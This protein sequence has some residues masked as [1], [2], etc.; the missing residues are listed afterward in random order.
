MDKRLLFRRILFSVILLL[1][2]GIAVAGYFERGDPSIFLK[3]LL[4]FSA[5]AVG[6]VSTF[7]SSV[8]RA[9]KD[10][11]RQGFQQASGYY[12]DEEPRAKRLFYRGYCAWATD[13]FSNANHYLTKAEKAAKLPAA[14]ARIQFYIGRSSLDEQRLGKALE[15]FQ[16]AVDSDS[17]FDQAWSN[18]ATVYFALNRPDEALACCQNA[19]AYNPRNGFAYN[20]MADYAYRSGDYEKACSLSARAVAELP[21]QPVMHMNYALSL[22][23]L[24]KQQEALEHYRIAVNGGYQ[25]PEQA[26]TQIQAHFDAASNLNTSADAAE[27]VQSK[28]KIKC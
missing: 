28:P 3:A 9:A 1:S 23:A 2:V 17:S 15:Y 26:L 25:E 20:K 11:V 19:L 14:K 4:P 27:P 7:Y 5:G 8:D 21:D 22:A 16:K 10:R 13:Q 6:L 12:F 24:G 18:L